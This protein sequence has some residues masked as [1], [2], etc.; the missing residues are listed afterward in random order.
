MSGPELRIDP[1]TGRR[2]IVA[3]SRGQRPGGGLE[4]PPPGQMQ[5]ADD[6][7]AEGHEAQ[8][9]PELYAIRPNTSA[10]DTPGW[11]VRVVPN[12]YPALVGADAFSSAPPSPAP[13]AGRPVGP[14]ITARADR[15]ADLFYRAPALGAHELI[16]N[17]S[18]QVVSLGQLELAELETALDVWRERL[19][20]H[21]DAACRHLIVNEQPAAGS[22]IAHTHAQLFALEFVPADIARERER[23]G[24]YATRTM[25]ANLLGDLIQEE[26]RKRERIVA[27]DREAVLIAPFASRVPFQL[28]LAPRVPRGRFEDAGACGAA[29]LHDALRRLARVL[30]S[31]P[32]LNMWV[33]TAPSG[34]D[35]YCWRIDILPR[36]TPMAGLELGAGIDLNTVSPEH[37]AVALREA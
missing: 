3:E 4:V 7:F 25:G 17:S 30:G 5:D 6:P 27:I 16:I 28:M 13:P 18:R 10:A 23:F 14:L 33:R 1:L 8:T 32:P 37:A 22:S 12:S 9:P 26:V 36:L 19:R 15:E 20:H 11:S 29:L 24:A 21:A 2:V 31:L 35:H 34:A